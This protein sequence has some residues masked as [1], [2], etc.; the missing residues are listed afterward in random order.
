VAAFCARETHLLEILLEERVDEVGS[1]GEPAV[2][3]RGVFLFLSYGT[4]TVLGYEPLATGLAFLPMIV[5]LM[6]A[7]QNDAGAPARRRQC[8]LDGRRRGS[9]GRR[10]G[11]RIRDGAGVLRRHPRRSR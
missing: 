7:A 11:H 9:R 10:S 5:S 3:R 1:L 8:L 6:V 2:H 4:S